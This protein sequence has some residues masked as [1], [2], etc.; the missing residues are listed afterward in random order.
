MSAG[1]HTAVV[2]RRADALWREVPDAVLVL[3]PDDSVVRLTGAG[4]ALWL[5]LEQPATVAELE[6]AFAPELADGL[7]GYLDE[8][9]QLGLVELSG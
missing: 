6:D 1:E 8:L 3:Q 7:P 4:K 5:V 2:R 9:A